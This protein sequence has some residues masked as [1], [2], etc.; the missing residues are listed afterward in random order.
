MHLMCIHAKNNA[1]G[2]RVT[3]RHT[4]IS[5]RKG[6]TKATNT[7]MRNANALPKPK[8]QSEQSVYLVKKS[9]ASEVTTTRIQK[10]P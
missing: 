3:Y 2:Q 8:C 9:A 10:M 5:D 4:I 7:Y 1:M 6:N